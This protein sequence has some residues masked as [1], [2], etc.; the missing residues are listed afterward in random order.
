MLSVIPPS[1]FEEKHIEQLVGKITKREGFFRKNLLEEITRKSMVWMPY[2]R[3]QFDYAHSEKDSI[4]RYGETALNGMFYRC[5]KSEKE[6]FMLFRPNYLKYKI[7][8]H[9]P[10]PKEI[11]GSIVP[12]NFEETLGNFLKRL[13]EVKDELSA[14]RRE[15]NKIRA[16]MRK[17]SAIL[18]P[19]KDSREKEKTLSEKVA[20]LEATKNILSLCLNTND[21]ISSMKVTGHD[22][23]YYPTLVI[24]LKHKENGTDRYL[25]VKLVKD[26]LIRKQL[27]YDGAL[28]ELCNENTMCKEVIAGTVMQ[29][30]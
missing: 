30:S 25:I 4:Q 18:P 5:V 2:Y 12:I 28:T 22:V 8:R 27:S 6:L 20:K 17:Y 13:N 14:Q 19:M 29:E 3:V 7:F 26:G 23:F 10:Q 11:V 21:D 16:N 15:L 9:S 1:E 24:A